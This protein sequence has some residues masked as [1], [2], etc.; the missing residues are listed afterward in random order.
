MREYIDKEEL[1][2]KIDKNICSYCNHFKN[3]NHSFA[4]SICKVSLVC[5]EI[6]LSTCYTCYDKEVI[7]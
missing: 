2:E 7:S 6:A 3:G 5:S 1:L 4:C